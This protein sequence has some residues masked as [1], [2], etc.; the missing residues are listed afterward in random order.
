MKGA[1][2][3]TVLFTLHLIL[4]ASA[5][6]QERAAPEDTTKVEQDSVAAGTPD[7]LGRLRVLGTL[8]GEFRREAHGPPFPSGTASASD[9]Y[10]RRLEIAVVGKLSDLAEAT[11]VVNTENL[12][13]PTQGGDGTIVLDEGH[14]D[15]AGGDTA[16]FYLTLGLQTQPFGLFESHSVTD[17]MTQDAYEIKK[18]GAVLGFTGPKEMDLSVTSYKGDELLS[19]LMQSGLFDAAAVGWSPPPIR[20]VNS[21]IFSG[22]VTPIDDRLDLFAS[23]ASEPGRNRRNLTYDAGLTLHA[24]PAQH[25]LLDVEYAKALR[26]ESYPLAPGQEF[27]EGAFSTSLSYQLVVRERETRGTNLKGRRSRIRSHPAEISA[28]FEH[29]DDGGMSRILH[30]WSTK[31]RVSVGGRYTIE[32]VGGG[33]LYFLAEYRYSSLRTPADLLDGPANG[34]NGEVY[35]R[36]GILF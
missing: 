4:P 16:P 10:L 3:F 1:G 27:R 2:V 5:A 19:H 11:F 17:P 15:V 28:R 32:D 30:L 34:T 33:S 9:L 35:L 24:P 18:V 31:D 8:E 21:F 12:G 29:F 23:L 6:G 22:R 13:D 20:N 14:I 7:W 26:R 25:I 36:A